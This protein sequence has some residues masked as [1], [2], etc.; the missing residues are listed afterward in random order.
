[1]VTKLA[2]EAANTRKSIGDATGTRRKDEGVGGRFGDFLAA[3][4]NK[5][6]AKMSSP[7]VPSIETAPIF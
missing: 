5:N 3:R 2:Q 1:M 4:R 7:S 6:I